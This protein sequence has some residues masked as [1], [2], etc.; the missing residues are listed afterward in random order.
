MTA[1]AFVSTVIGATALVSGSL[2]ILVLKDYSFFDRKPGNRKPSAK[3]LD[4][5]TPAVRC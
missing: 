4:F 1:L 3:S 2:L 5:S